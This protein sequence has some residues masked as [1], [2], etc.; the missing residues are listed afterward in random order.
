MLLRRQENLAVMDMQ[1][2]GKQS[3]LTGLMKCKQHERTEQHN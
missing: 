2:E 3:S 1:V